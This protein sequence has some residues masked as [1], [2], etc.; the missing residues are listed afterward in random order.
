M[1]SDVNSARCII[2]D[3]QGHRV[4]SGERAMLIHPRLA[5]IIL[6]A[7]NY[8]S[9][10]QL[11]DLCSEIRD[12]TDD[13][14]LITVDQEGGRVQRFREGFSS[15]PPVAKFGALYQSDPQDARRQAR[16]TAFTMAWELKRAGVDLSYAPVADV[17]HGVSSVIGDRAFHADPEIAA[18]LCQEWIDGMHEAGMAAVI[19][20]FPGHGGVSQ[21]SHLETPTDDRDLTTLSNED[22]KPFARLIESGV[23]AVMTAHVDYRNIDSYLPT[24]SRF[25][26]KEILRKQ[27]GFTGIIF[28]DD[29]TMA[30]AHRA[31]GPLERAQAARTAGCD[32][33][34]VCNDQPAAI[35]VLNGLDDIEA[36]C[37]ADHHNVDIRI[38]KGPAVSIDSKSA[39]DRVVAFAST[40]ELLID[41]TGTRRIA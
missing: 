21:D 41:Q 17:N 25:W 14:F 13:D 23:E 32:L 36:G 4:A 2:A 26:L 35:E 16:E 38:L 10:S 18:E 5:G 30:G 29:L 33:L 24:Y 1:N 3:L 20:H 8:Q 9:E 34:L 31:G 40:L 39:D 12:I 27:L 37:S 28:S 19:K 15:L 6:F 7:R 22:M 11:R